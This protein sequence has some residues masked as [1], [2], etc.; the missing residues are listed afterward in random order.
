MEAANPIVVTSVA[1]IVIAIIFLTIRD[2]QECTA[3]I[4]GVHDRNM[5]E[6]RS[7]LA[8]GH[9][10]DCQDRDGWTP[11]CHAAKLSYND[12]TMEFLHKGS[13]PVRP[14]FIAAEYDS[15]TVVNALI[16]YGADPN[17]DYMGQTAL[18]IAVKKS[19]RSTI[20]ILLEREA[21]TNLRYVS[22]ATS[23]LMVSTI[24]LFCTSHIDIFSMYKLDWSR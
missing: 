20:N 5:T 24:D 2:T 23:L 8:S 9:A 19:H 6:I 12:V 3:L 21:N 1:V 13:D 14:L 18:H 16:I 15:Y 17:L 11:L 22:E 4:K 7:L 10:I